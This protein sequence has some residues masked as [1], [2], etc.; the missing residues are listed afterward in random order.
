ML[1]GIIVFFA[2]LVVITLM[3]LRTWNK[4]MNAR[5]TGAGAHCPSHQNR[6]CATPPCCGYTAKR[7]LPSAFGT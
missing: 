6:K 7:A 1:I 4:G 2:L 3:I 5:Q